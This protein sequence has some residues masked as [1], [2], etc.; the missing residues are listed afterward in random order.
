MMLALVLE[1]VRRRRLRIGYSLLWLLVGGTAMTL[2]LFRGLLGGLAQL[3]GVES[4]TSLLFTAGIAFSL[5]ILL[6]HSLTLTVLWRQNKDLAQNQALL[7]WRIRQLETRLD[8]HPGF[9]SEPVLELEAHEW[10]TG[11]PFWAQLGLPVDAVESWQRDKGYSWRAES[12]PVSL[13]P[14]NYAD[15]TLEDISHD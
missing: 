15:Q 5:V 14:V 1:L 7:E 8:A 4:P 10:V 6:E 3:I 12:L 11:L 9:R 2:I 13:A